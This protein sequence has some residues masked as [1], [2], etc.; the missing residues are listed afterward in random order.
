M[1]R[2]QFLCL[3]LSIL[4]T[5]SLSAWSPTGH[6]VVDRIAKERLTVNSQALITELLAVKVPPVA[7]GAS[8]LSR[9]LILQVAVWQIT[10]AFVS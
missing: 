8:R 1:K 6:M 9:C 4:S 7:L 2:L 10:R 3:L 5:N